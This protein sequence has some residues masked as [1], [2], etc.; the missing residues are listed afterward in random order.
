MCSNVPRPFY[1]VKGSLVCETVPTPIGTDIVYYYSF[2]MSH[3][4]G[5][6]DMVMW[7]EQ[8]SVSLMVPMLTT[9]MWLVMNYD[10]C[11]SNETWNAETCKL[12]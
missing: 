5:L 2:R 8:G 4:T 6:Q 10:V 1:H 7:R 3:Y 9:K 11:Q 12:S